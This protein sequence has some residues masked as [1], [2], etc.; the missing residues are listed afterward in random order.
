MDPEYAGTA[1]RDLST[2]VDSDTEAR[3][4]AILAEFSQSAAILGQRL[5]EM[6]RVLAQASDDPAFAPEPVTEQKCTEWQQSIHA[7]LQRALE[8]LANR[9][10]QLDALDQQ[11]A[12]VLLACREPLDEVV[13][14]L[15][16]AGLGSLCTRTHGDLHLGQ[17]LVAHGDAYFIDFEGEPARPLAER[18]AKSSPLRDVAGILRSFDYATATAA[19]NPS[20]DGIDQCQQQRHELIER[21][22]VTSEQAFLAAYHQAA[23]AIPHQWEDPNGAQALIQ[24]FTLEKAVYEIAYEAAHRPS[25]LGIP[26]RGLLA[27][28]HR[29]G[30]TAATTDNLTAD[31][32][33]L[34]PLDQSHE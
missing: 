32:V 12:A 18:R 6:H 4:T 27:I 23:A 10:A 31:A 33:E 3:Q 1:M 30:I 14:S 19:N 13:A 28:A 2:A 9:T 25:W 29:L 26:L 17:V 34:R 15:A 8:V 5:G 7:Q 20:V 16:R 24:L 21:F 22:R 11:R